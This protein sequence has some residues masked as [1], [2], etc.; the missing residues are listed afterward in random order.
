MPILYPPTGSFTSDPGALERSELE[1]L[2]LH[3]RHNYRGLM[4]SRGHEEG[5]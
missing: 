3:L 2:Y 5:D 1:T 4:V